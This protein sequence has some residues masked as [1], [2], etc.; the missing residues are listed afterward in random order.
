MEQSH[1]A[2]WDDT[3]ITCYVPLCTDM[4]NCVTSVIILLALQV[5]IANK[6]YLAFL[7]HQAI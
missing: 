3:V 7:Q 6:M 2:R 5:L 4:P 1:W